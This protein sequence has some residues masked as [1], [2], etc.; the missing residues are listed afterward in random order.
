MVGWSLM[1]KVELRF[2]LARPLDA[3]LLPR[4]SDLRAV[5][6]IKAANVSPSQESLTVEYDATRLQPADVEAALRRAGIP[7]AAVPA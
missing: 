6:G 4:L 5:Y 1:T 3:S 7:L 2:R